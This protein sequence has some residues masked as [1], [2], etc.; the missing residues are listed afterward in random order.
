[1]NPFDWG[2]DVN[3]PRKIINYP[4]IDFTYWDYQNTWY[5]IFSYENP[6]RKHTWFIRISPESLKYDTPNRVFNW[7]QCFSPDF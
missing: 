1:M 6:Q 3:K 4:T 7:W 5:N 2:T